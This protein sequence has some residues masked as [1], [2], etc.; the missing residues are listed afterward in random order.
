MPAAVA[1]RSHAV[2]PAFLRT[3]CLAPRRSD[4][5]ATSPADN[6]VLSFDRCMRRRRISWARR[7]APNPCACASLHSA[8]DHIHSINA[9]QGARIDRAGWEDSVGMSARVSRP[10]LFAELPRVDSSGRLRY[11]LKNASDALLPAC[12]RTCITIRFSMRRQAAA[13][14]DRPPPPRVQHLWIERD[15]CGAASSCRSVFFGGQF[16]CSVGSEWESIFK[17]FDGVLSWGAGRAIAFIGGAAPPASEDG[18]LSYERG[19]IVHRSL[20]WSSFN[21]GEAATEPLMHTPAWAAP[22]AP[23]GHIKASGGA[24]FLPAPSSEAERRASATLGRHEFHVAWLAVQDSDFV[25]RRCTAADGDGCVLGHDASAVLRARFSDA[26]ATAAAGGMCGSGH[27]YARRPAFLAFGAR[28]AF[29][30]FYGGARSRAGHVSRRANLKDDHYIDVRD[31]LRPPT[32]PVPRSPPYAFNPRWTSERERESSLCLSSNFALSVCLS[33]DACHRYALCLCAWNSWT[34][35]QI[36]QR[37]AA[38]QRVRLHACTRR[39]A[40]CSFTTSAKTS[41][42]PP[43][44]CSRRRGSIAIQCGT[45]GSPTPSPT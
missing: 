18:T 22:V 41:Q 35:M 24:S 36:A 19:T 25:R 26:N 13:A 28:A 17:R 1:V 44:R 10:H 9:W 15:P 4:R 42:W 27:L 11:A 3:T 6:E 8:A 30:Q 12:Y 32:R 33:I 45:W 29:V 31:C 7:G 16:A 5:R 37:L 43:S 14:V 23:L 38:Y 40:G 39:S 20:A 2:T 21:G 34:A